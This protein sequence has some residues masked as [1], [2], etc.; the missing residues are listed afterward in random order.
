MFALG[1]VTLVVC[2]P[3]YPGSRA[4]AQPTMDALARALSRASG[5]EIQAVYEEAEAKGL[6][7]LSRKD[8]ALL[9]SPLPFWFTHRT[10]LKLD[11]KLT[12]VP[13][14]GAPLEQ[15]TLV[16]GKGH[17]ASLE[18]YA[19]L[20][21][22]GYAPQFVHAVAPALPGDA[23]VEQTANVLTALRRASNGE[24]VAVLL[25]GTQSAALEKLP[26]AAQL[27]TVQTSPKVPGALVSVVAARLDRKRAQALLQA[28]QRLSQSDEGRAALAGAQ[29][30]GFVAVDAAA[31]A[32]LH[33]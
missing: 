10:K 29:L 19:A 14:G 21:T 8:A 5:Q 27:E 22:A 31:L 20:S 26:F 4:E 15:W 3:G 25:D 30:S 17:P 18:G 13:Q 28:F 1:V 32:A 33:P 12:A 16:A 24:K 23:K 7:R 2:A 6:E 9:L 11:A